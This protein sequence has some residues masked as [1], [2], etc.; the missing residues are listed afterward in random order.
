[1]KVIVNMLVNFMSWFCRLKISFIYFAFD[2]Y[3]SKNKLGH[4][5][6]RT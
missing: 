1:M 5:L 6:P 2:V 3:I 4:L